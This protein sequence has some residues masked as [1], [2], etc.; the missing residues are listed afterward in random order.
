LREAQDISNINNRCTNIEKILKK[1]GLASKQ[2]LQ[3]LPSKSPSAQISA[4][5]VYARAAPR[6]PAVAQ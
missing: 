1:V 2:Q 6:V 3:M 5:N 4:G